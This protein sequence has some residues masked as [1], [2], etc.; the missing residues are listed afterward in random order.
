MQEIMTTTAIGFAGT[1]YTLWYISEETKQVEP[2]R[3]STVKQYTYVKNIS[4]D[5]ETA[6]EKYP[7]AVYLEEL[8]GKSASFERTSYSW[9]TV[10]TFRFGKYSNDRI[11]DCGDTS[12]IEWYWNNVSG[13]HR[14]YVSEVLKSR[15]YEVRTSGSGDYW[16]VS[17]E[18]VENERLTEAK[19]DELEQTRSNGDAVEVHVEH[20]PD[21]EGYIW[22]EDVLYHFQ[23]VRENDYRGFPYYLPVLN[24][25]A[26]RV[27]GKTVRVTK[28]T[29]KRED[30]RIVVEV[31]DFEIMK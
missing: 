2:H 30:R 5:R 24:G 25:K 27:K 26:K 23:E 8:R 29:W 12:Y 4:M 1:F 22:D 13:D 31:L 28:Y 7:D 3:I 6:I 14:D 17:P 15:G 20:N 11:E 16:L 19:L 18:V 21:D 10:E 9:D